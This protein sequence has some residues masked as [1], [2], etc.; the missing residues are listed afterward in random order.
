MVRSLLNCL[1]EIKSNEPVIR[2]FSSRQSLDVEGSCLGPAVGVHNDVELLVL[3][4]ELEAAEVVA[5]VKLR[6]EAALHVPAC[7]MEE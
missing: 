4:V 6:G 5:G 7:I 2:F 1:R 3:V